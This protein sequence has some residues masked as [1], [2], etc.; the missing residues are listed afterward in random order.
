MRNPGNGVATVEIPDCASLHPG[1]ESMGRN[2][3]AY[4]AISAAAK[5]AA[6]DVTGAS[7]GSTT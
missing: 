4:A 6:A 3:N 7:S 1:D 2:G 5:R